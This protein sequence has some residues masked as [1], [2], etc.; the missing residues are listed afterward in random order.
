MP[1]GP[2]L[3]TRTVLDGR[4]A[5]RVSIGGRTTEWRH[6]AAAWRLLQ[7]MADASVS[8]FAFCQDRPR[9]RDNHAPQFD[10]G[11]SSTRLRFGG[12]E[13]RRRSST[14]IAP[15]P[16]RRLVVELEEEHP[17][18]RR[19]LAPTAPTGTCRG[20][21]A[22]RGGP[23]DPFHLRARRA[24]RDRLGE[25]ADDGDDVALADRGAEV[26]ELTHD[27]T[28]TGSSPTSSPLRAAAS[29]GVSPWS[30]RPPGKLISPR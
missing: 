7:A 8:Q 15:S 5:L 13:A 11:T 1:P 10:S 25:R 9:I 23:R 12:G 3:F 4:T 29:T 17:P 30:T 2:A 14:T 28:R 19:R 16:P 21:R 18:V 26:L 20:G 6:V 27:L 22:R 24:Q